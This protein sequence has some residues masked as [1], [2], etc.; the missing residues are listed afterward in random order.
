MTKQLHFCFHGAGGLGSVVG[1]FLA[2]G[3]HKVT[4][5]ARKAHVEAIRRDGLHI[6][7]VRAQFVQRDNLFA[8]ETPEE[9]EGD[10]DYY[11]LLT[12][13]KGTDQA[14]ADAKVLVDRAACSLTLQNGVG[15]EGKLQS[16]FGRNKVIGG[17]IMDG[18]TL[19]APGR[20]LNHM[21]VPVTAYFG[22]LEGGESDRTRVMADALDQAG[23]G[24]RST[25]D[26]VHVHWEK[27]V[28]VGG[29]SSWSASTLG[30]IPKLDFVDGVAVR[31]G[32]EQYVH[33]VKDLISIYKALGY[34][35]QNFF[36][37]VSRLIEI[38]KEGFE[39]AVAGV[40]AMVSRFKPENRP[41]RTSMHDDLVAGRS[42]EVDEVLGPLAA[43]AERLQVNAPSFLGA[44][45][46]LKTLNSYL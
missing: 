29:A 30:A 7:G 16:V 31:E 44:Y 36:A 22:E 41:V 4:L 6:D 1:G 34:A 39:D 26:I 46:V 42:M 5:I 18:A 35:P 10:I 37:P 8:V 9:V 3:G 21:A 32:A 20:A 12:K 17:S 25:P 28:Q 14:L 24:S 27:V 13:A 15:K 11:I 2:R 43:A 45:R 38:D 40:M 33:I 23:M 19:M